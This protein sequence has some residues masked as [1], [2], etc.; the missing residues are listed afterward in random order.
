M[1]NACT[2]HRAIPSLETDIKATP[3]IWCWTSRFRG[4]VR[5]EEHTSE[6]QSHLNL[7]CRLLLENK[8]AVAVGKHHH[9][10][11]RQDSVRVVTFDVVALVVGRVPVVV[12]VVSADDVVQRACGLV[13]LR[14]DV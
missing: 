7:G 1:A 3:P 10:V 9:L 4:E 13:E 14:I 6:L 11:G 2:F 12:A 8:N 5:S